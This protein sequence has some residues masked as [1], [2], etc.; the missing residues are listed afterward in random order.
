VR[1]D[2]LGY[3]GQVGLEDG[4]RAFGREVPRGD[5][6]AAG[7]ED[8]PGTLRESASDG[9]VDGIRSVRHRERDDVV[10]AVLGE[11]ARQERAGAVL[12]LTAGAA[13]RHGDDG[14][15]VATHG[16][17]IITMARLSGCAGAASCGV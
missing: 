3:P 17:T 6:G 9:L 14:G 15:T 12:G 4:P 13:V 11:E 8:E 7:R 1:P 16:H 10:D 2:R 5:A